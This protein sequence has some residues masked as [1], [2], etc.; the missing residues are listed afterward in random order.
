[1]LNYNPTTK[2]ELNKTVDAIFAECEEWKLKEKFQPKRIDPKQIRN[3]YI[4][5]YGKDQYDRM[6]KTATR[7]F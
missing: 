2:K 5:K 3:K 7:F 1:M 6:T 4:E